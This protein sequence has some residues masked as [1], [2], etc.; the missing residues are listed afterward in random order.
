MLKQ[1]LFIVLFGIGINVATAQEF[2][3]MVEWKGDSI[4]YVKAERRESGDMEYISIISDSKVSIIFSFELVSTF[5]TSYKN[6]YL[7]SAETKQL[8]N[9]RVQDESTIEYRD[10]QYIVMVED[11]VSFIEE[12]IP[13]GITQ[14][15]FHYP[16]TDRIFSERFGE[17]CELLPLGNNQFRLN[18]PDGNHNIYTYKNNRCEEVE[19]N[20]RLTKIFIKRIQ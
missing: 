16:K 20:T 18:K 6:G 8:L 11:D 3:Y 2:L 1:F 17:Y 19:V 5:E 10:N 13:F 4:G 15:Y 12:P 9:N 7:Y 14:L